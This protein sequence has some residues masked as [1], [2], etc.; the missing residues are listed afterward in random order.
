MLCWCLEWT[1][2]GIW[3]FFIIILKYHNVFPRTTVAIHLRAEPAVV[4]QD[5]ISL[6]KQTHG[7]KDLAKVEKQL[8]LCLC[9][10]VLR[11][12]SLI[13]TP[14][15]HFI[16]IYS[17]GKCSLGA[18]RPPEELFSQQMMGNTLLFLAGQAFIV[19]FLLTYG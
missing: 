6:N 9:P 12:Y 16:M 8:G 15:S 5:A 3:A 2:R 17:G 11:E 10:T 1:R 18:G 13:L 4:P 7:N 14:A 19:C